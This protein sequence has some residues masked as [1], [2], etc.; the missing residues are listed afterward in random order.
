MKRSQQQRAIAMLHE[1]DH[2]KRL[3]HGEISHMYNGQAVDRG[4]WMTVHT[5]MLSFLIAHTCSCRICGV[6]AAAAAAV[7]LM[8]LTFMLCAC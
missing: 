5:W 8:M 2:E 3:L 6:V 4:S 7:A 1:T